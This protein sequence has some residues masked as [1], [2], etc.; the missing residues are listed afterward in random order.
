MNRNI[1]ISLVVLSL[2]SMIS[3]L[4]GCSTLGLGGAGNTEGIHGGSHGS[5]MKDNILIRESIVNGVKISAEFPPYTL[6][7]ELAYK[8]S[9]YDVNGKTTIPNASI[10]L[11]VIN[12][13]TDNKGTH[14]GPGGSNTGHGGHGPNLND[15]EPAQ[16]KD[17]STKFYPDEIN[18]GTYIFRPLIRNK[19]NY[20]FKFVVDRIGNTDL[21]Q[22]IEIEQAVQF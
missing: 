20:K 19:G 4:S 5:S 9:L 22:P 17:A 16:S 21:K 3:L 14:S 11:I 7:D 15:S 8:V 1:G 6:K 12:N 13:D 10:V 2:V 18:N